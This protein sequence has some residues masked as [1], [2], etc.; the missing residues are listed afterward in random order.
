MA[1]A[2]MVSSRISTDARVRELASPIAKLLFTWLIPHADNRGRLRAEPG[3]VRNQVIPHETASD[4]DVACWLRQMHELGLIVLYEADGGH[5][6]EL[7]AWRKHQRLDR[8]QRSD[9]PDPPVA[10]SP[11]D[12]NPAVTDRKPSAVR[13]G[14][15]GEVEESEKEVRGEAE[16]ERGNGRGLGNGALHATNCTCEVC[17]NRMITRTGA[18]AKPTTHG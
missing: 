18:K 2:R 5:F 17:W 15:E 4:A 6:L 14:I 8:M 11:A 3:L 1:R 9:L 16:G 12:R 13:S 7:T 10:E